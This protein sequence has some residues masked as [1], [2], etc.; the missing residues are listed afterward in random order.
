EMDRK[1]GDRFSP[2]PKDPND[3]HRHTGRNGFEHGLH[4]AGSGI[5]PAA[6]H[7]GVERGLLPFFVGAN[8][9]EG[10]FK[11]ERYFRSMVGYGKTICFHTLTLSLPGTRPIA[12]TDRREVR[13][14][15][16]RHRALFSW[17]SA[18]SISGCPMEILFQRR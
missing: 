12:G 1:I 14:G 3:V 10:A 15:P 17:G 2:L 7:A 16:Y 8:E 9:A 6:F 4:R 5:G 11:M 13:R 18:I